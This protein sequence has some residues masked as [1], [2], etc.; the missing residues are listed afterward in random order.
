MG[1]TAIMP[2]DALEPVNKQLAAPGESASPGLSA[3]DWEALRAGC[4]AAWP[5]LAWVI[6]R[7]T[8]DRPT[9]TGKKRRGA[10]FAVLHIWLQYNGLLCVTLTAPEPLPLRAP[11]TNFI[12]AELAIRDVPTKLPDMLAE[13]RTWWT[14]ATKRRRAS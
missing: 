2:R 8:S 9:V 13:A 1:T 4:A 7:A 14:T 5:E 6:C 11:W 12:H 10:Y 3:A